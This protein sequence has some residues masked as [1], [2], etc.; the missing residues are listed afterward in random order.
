MFL[1]CERWRSLLN[2]ETASEFQR[3]I[4][5]LD[6][7]G[8]LQNSQPMEMELFCSLTWKEWKKNFKG[9]IQSLGNH[10]NPSFDIGR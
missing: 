10:C 9:I 3:G 2:L 7:S 5:G 8:F 4:V 1:S 6:Y